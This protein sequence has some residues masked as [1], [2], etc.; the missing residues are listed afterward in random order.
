MLR[1]IH[2]IAG[3]VAI[4]AVSTFWLSTAFSE[5]FSSRATVIAVKMA[6]PWGF[7]L[8][9]PALAVTGSSGLLLSKGQRQGVVGVKRKCLPFIAANGLL[10]L[11]PAALFLASK[12]KV[13]NFDAEFYAVQALELT[14]G[15]LN[16]TLL[17]LNMRAGLAL[18]RWRRKSFLQPAITCSTFLVSKKQVA[19]G[20]LAFSISRPANFE[21]VAGQ[22]VYV[23]IPDLKK[24][25][26]KGNVRIFSIASSPQDLELE[27]ATRQTDSSLKRYLADTPAGASLQ[28]E[29]PYGDMALHADSSRPAVFLAGGIGITPFR[30]MVLDAT[31]RASP[32]HLFLFYSNR[33]LEDAPFLTELRQLQEKNSKFK[34]IT[35]F[36]EDSA[37]SEEDAVERGYITAA[38]ISK[39]VGDMSVPIYYIAGPATMVT[40]MEAIL[41]NAGVRQADVRTEKFPCY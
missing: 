35:T 29:G 7:L 32:H 33:R 18:T 37:I 30:S 1:I 39:H 2:P 22:A 28:L 24:A 5:L 20:T 15:A 13:G 25:D 6:I 8:L 21:F 26:T 10:I 12:A 4:L 31:N 14:A 27:I 3:L 40:A 11:M 34:L 41:K 16:I 9:V 23:T 17:F 38:M 19:K 36:T